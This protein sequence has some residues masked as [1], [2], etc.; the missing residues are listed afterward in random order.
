MIVSE[1][2][3]L[4]KHARHRHPLYRTLYWSFDKMVVPLHPRS[5]CTMLQILKAVHPRIAWTSEGFRTSLSTHT[6]TCH[7]YHCGHMGV[8]TMHIVWIIQYP[9]I[10]LIAWYRRPQKI[11]KYSSWMACRPSKNPF[12]D[13]N[14]SSMNK[15]IIYVKSL[16]DHLTRLKKPTMGCWSS[17]SQTLLASYPHNLTIGRIQ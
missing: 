14:S 8:L 13:A 2:Q 7:N 1:A 17:S 15:Y 10:T 4:L 11:G 3:D 12:Q 16:L 6:C 9:Y 5:T